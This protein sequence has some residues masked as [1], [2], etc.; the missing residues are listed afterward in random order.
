MVSIRQLS[1]PDNVIIVPGATQHWPDLEVDPVRQT[2]LMRHIAEQHIRDGATVLAVGPHELDWLVS[3]AGRTQLT[4]VTRGIPDA[5][6][7]GVALPDITVYCGDPGRL[8]TGVGAFDVV[9]AVTDLAR[10]L[11]IESDDRP[12]RT[13]HDELRALVAPG[14]R[15]ILGIENDLGLHRLAGSANPL[16]R[17]DDS[18][19]A[20]VATWDE[21][22]PRTAAQ[23]GDL[24]AEVWTCYPRWQEVG[25]AQT[26]ELSPEQA[27]SRDAAVLDAAVTPLLGPD[28]AWYLTAAAAAGRTPDLAAGWIVVAAVG[29]GGDASSSGADRAA[30]GA[31]VLRTDGA[32]EV[33]QVPAAPTAAARSALGVIVTAMAAHDLPT[34]RRTLT[35]WAAGVAGER[36]AALGTTLITPDHDL[37]TIGAPGDAELTPWQELARLVALIRGRAWRTPWPAPTTGDE[38]LA[39]L[40]AMAGLGELSDA[41]LGRLRV[42][43]PLGDDEYNHF[44]R[45][46]LV[47]HIA[48]QNE[49][50]ATLRSRVTWSELQFVT[51]KMSRLAVHAAKKG[52]RIVR[53]GSARLRGLV[54]R[55]D[56]SGG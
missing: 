44:D 45:H 22:R 36:P 11:P 24:G 56:V 46:E 26:G 16:A 3:L 31:Q 48:R 52:V 50:I 10:V 15:L 43:V 12:W 27:A 53:G 20:P 49:L 7:I 37:A 51:K 8:P 41:E 2:S 4:V 47:A 17:N 5:A 6:T 32:G 33:V 9:L 38:L 29:T 25:V 28:P 18:D 14:G 35:A 19:W 21:S 30:A 1:Y 34:L 55:S 54:G 39:L 23:A 13:L 40:G 42:A